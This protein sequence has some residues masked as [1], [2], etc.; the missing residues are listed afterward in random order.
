M[1]KKKSHPEFVRALKARNLKITVVGTYEN[2]LSRVA[3]RCDVCG[4]EW[5]P[6]GGSLLRGYGCPKCAGTMR[7]SHAEFVEELKSRR[8]DV[9]IVGP[10]VKALEKTRFRFLKCGHEWDVTPAHILNGRGCPLCAHSRRGASQRLTMERFLKRLHKIDRNLVVRE[11]GKYVNY[12]TPIPLRC[13]ACKYEYEV[14]PSDVL[15]GGGC[16]NCHRACTSFPEQFIRHAFVRMLGESEVLSRDKTAA[17]VE[18]DVCIPALRAAVEPGSWYWHRNLVERDREKRLLCERKGIRLITVY[19]HYDETAVPFDDCLV[20]PCDLA[21]RRNMD[22]LVAVTKTL[23]GAFGLDSN[24]AAG[25]WETIRRRAELDSRRMTTEEFRAELAGINDKIEVIGEYTRASDK[26][27]VRC[28]VCNHEWSVAPTTLRRGSG[29]ASCAGRLKLSHERFVERL[30]L[31]HPEIVPLTEYVNSQ[32][33]MTFECRAC[34]HVWSAQAY[35]L[36][37][38]SRSSGCRK[39]SVRAM[40]RRRSQK[41]R[42]ITTGEVFDTLREA[43]AKYGVS[44]SAISQCCSEPPKLKRAGGREWEY[45]D[46]L[47]GER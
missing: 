44:R 8:D 24:L 25:E 29:C 30:N 19:D 31:L 47:S 46:L 10:Y 41:V 33:R 36:I 32:T 15:H 34:G 21:S 18:L 5:A 39:C 1:M 37:A 26:I 45:V 35:S 4:W 27:R 28:K 38:K 20:T 6:V 23:F 12:T 2:C 11:G 16:P 14:K 43:A 40:L 9:I 17:G 3:V 22:K 42:C 7:K 13:N